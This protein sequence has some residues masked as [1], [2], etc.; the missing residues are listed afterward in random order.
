M[1]KLNSTGMTC[2]HSD[3]VSMACLV[4]QSIVSYTGERIRKDLTC[5]EELVIVVC[6]CQLKRFFRQ[7]KARDDEKDMDHRPTGIDYSYEW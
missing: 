3:F 7:H 5:G 4:A 2:P 6:A 1:R